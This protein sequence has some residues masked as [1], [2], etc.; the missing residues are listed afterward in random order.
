[1]YE[2]SNAET[3]LLGLLSEGEK[4][5]YLIEKDVQE[6][7]M[8]YWTDLSMSSIYKFLNRLEEAELIESR[9][10]IT[11]ENRMRKVYNLTET[12]LATLKEKLIEM[13]RE[14]E[15]VKWR[16]DIAVSNLGLLDTGIAIDYLK[17]YKIELEKL[18]GRYH[19]LE[20]YLKSINCKQHT[21]ALA[22]RPVHLLRGDLK[23]VEEYI[24][25]LGD[26]NA[27]QNNN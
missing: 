9:K 1:M 13:I 18:I 5:G 14:P 17:L 8:R 2:L 16:I 22:K 10:E 25:E 23:W 11:E 27:G 21:L 26:A 6:R 24:Q 20:K 12:G 3:A 4:H 15:H 7:D 19:E